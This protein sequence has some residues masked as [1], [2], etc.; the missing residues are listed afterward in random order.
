MRGSNSTNYILQ[1]K[2]DTL[3]DILAGIGCFYAVKRIGAH[4]KKQIERKVAHILCI[5]LVFL[6]TAVPIFALHPY[7]GTYYNLCWKVVDI[8][9]I[10]NIG[11]ASGLDLAAKYLN[12]KP[13]A[14]QL[15][16]QTSDLGSELLRY[17]FVGTVYRPDRNRF[18]SGELRRADYEVVYI[19]DFQIG[20]VPQTGTRDGELE[21]CITINGNVHA[22]IY[23]IPCTRKP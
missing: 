23:R 13:N 4:F 11:S 6:L 17:Y 21:A 3:L 14:Q 16:V 5:A 9:K 15:S 7:Y 1:Q 19:R 18:K 2:V 8:T 10:I 20:R 22:W 12:N